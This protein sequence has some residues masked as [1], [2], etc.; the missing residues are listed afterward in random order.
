M[1]EYLK[2]NSDEAL[3][4]W[5]LYS[6]LSCLSCWQLQFLPLTSKATVQ[7]RVHNNPRTSV[8]ACCLQVRE[9]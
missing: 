7:T 6:C 5:M 8:T 4:V 3:K 1:N 2:K 9:Y